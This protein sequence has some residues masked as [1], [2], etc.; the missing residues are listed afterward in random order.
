[1]LQ[2]GDRRVHTTLHGPSGD[3]LHL[4]DLPGRTLTEVRELESRALTCGSRPIASLARWK[5]SPT[6]AC[7]SGPCS[8]DASESLGR[9]ASLRPSKDRLRRRSTARLRALSRIHVSR[10]PRRGIEGGTCAPDLEERVLDQ[11][12][13][14]GLV[15]Q[16]RQTQAVDARGEP[17]VELAGRLSLIPQERRHQVASPIGAS[18]V[19]PFPPCC[20]VRFDRSKLGRD[21]RSA[22]DGIRTLKARIRTEPRLQERSRVQAR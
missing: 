5:R 22:I 20:A 6:S 10:E 12:F 16:E 8:S 14:I 19:V 11:V 15:P 2:G 1:M 4:R 21:G 17:I 3:A 9:E 13:R 18:I 7:H